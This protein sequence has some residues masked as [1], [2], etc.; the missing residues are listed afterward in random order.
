[1]GFIS[2]RAMDNLRVCEATINAKQCRL[3]FFC[4][5]DSKDFSKAAILQS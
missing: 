2:A 4:T 3:F 5:A 1:M